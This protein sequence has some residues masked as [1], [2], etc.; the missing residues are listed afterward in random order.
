[1]ADQ[2]RHDA[3]GW[4]GA[5]PAQTPRIDALAQRAARF[6][7]CFTQAPVCS[8]ARHSL[9][10]GLYVHQHGVTQNPAPGRDVQPHDHMRTIA[11]HLNEHG[12]RCFQ[13]GHMHWVDGVDNGYEP[14]F[15]GYWVEH[16]AWLDTLSPQAR[17]RWHAE[18]DLNPIRTTTA[19][20]GPR[21]AD[22]H[23]GH[24]V[25]KRT[26]EQLERSASDGRP[27][28]GW[29]SFTEPHP[30]WRPPHE[31]YEKVDP[32]TIELPPPWDPHSHAAEP[33]PYLRSKWEHLTDYERRQMIAAYF[34]MVALLDRYVGRVLD[35]L[36]ETGLAESTAVIFL[37]DHGDQLGEDGLFLKFVMRDASLR[38][39]LLIAGPG[40]Q[41]GDVDALVEHVDLFPTICDLLDVPIPEGLPGRSL[42]PLAAGEPV[43]DGWRTS[44]FSQIG[45]MRGVRTREASMTLRGDEPV[46]L[47]D[48]ERDPGQRRNVLGDARY[49]PMRRSL[50]GVLE[51]WC[52]EASLHGGV[53][54]GGVA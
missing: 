49:E 54:G 27:F 14:D 32:Q 47:F 23:Y 17:E 46:E 3:M 28:L 44:V 12:F 18:N 8:P 22:E 37:S 9:H 1:M 4:K 15:R 50:F 26:V 41:A 31:F 48:L 39:P 29:V 13:H 52:A 6:H 16:D 25:A 42:S 33:I 19:G 2:L 5:T 11:H 30:P 20:P 34:A 36:E 10:T 7:N 40:V 24:F 51:R 38:T 35:T 43:D 21:S 53:D 45:E